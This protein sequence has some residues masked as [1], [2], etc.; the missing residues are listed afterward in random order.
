MYLVMLVLYQLSVS[1]Y[2][3]KIRWALDH[4]RLSH[5]T[6]SLLPGLHVAKMAKMGL[7]SSLPV[8][9]HDVIA[10]FRWS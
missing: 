9:R 1:H 10:P 7:K 8:L 5:R 4:K 2:C 3:E 6:E